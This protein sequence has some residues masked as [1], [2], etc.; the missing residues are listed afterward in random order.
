MSKNQMRRYMIAGIIF[1]VFSVISFAAPFERNAVFWLAYIFGAVSILYQ[2]Y[3]FQYAFAEG[4]D[5]KSKFYG[6]PIARV[7]VIY[8]CIQ[9]VL[10]LIEMIAAGH[11]KTWVAVIL[12]VLPLAFALIGI[13]AADTVRDEAVNQDIKKHV[14]VSVMK[15]LKEKAAGLPALCKDS[16]SVKAVRN[17]AEEFKYSDPVSGEAT[18]DLEMVLGNQLDDLRTAVKN[19]NSQEIISLANT[20]L[21]TLKER[22]RISKANK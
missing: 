21:E 6:F 14:V 11:I 3:V 22:N 7:G 16:D 19:G 10:S 4:S 1:V 15:E 20:A 8:M 5:I 12:N 17:L 9:I 2:I 18:A 13:I